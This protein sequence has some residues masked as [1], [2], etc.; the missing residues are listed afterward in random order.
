MKA[1]L[2]H[3][4]SDHFFIIFILGPII[5]II[6]NQLQLTLEHHRSHLQRHDNKAPDT[7]GVNK[8]LPR[9]ITLTFNGLV[10]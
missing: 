9:T 3:H 6:P 5:I 10:H 8:Q 7:P 1:K 2:Y 4:W